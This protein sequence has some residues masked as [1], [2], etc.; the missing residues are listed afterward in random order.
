[1]C[2]GGGGIGMEG[3]PRK[4]R[5]RPHPQEFV[6][7][8]KGEQGEARRDKPNEKRLAQGVSRNVVSMFL[9]DCLVVHWLGQYSCR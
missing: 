6:V 1:V 8:S 4:V 3:D 7:I 2:V 5:V 9:P